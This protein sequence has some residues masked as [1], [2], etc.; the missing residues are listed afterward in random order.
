MVSEAAKERV[1]RRPARFAPLFSFASVRCHSRHRFWPALTLASRINTR[2]AR[3]GNLAE[4]ALIPIIPDETAFPYSIRVESLIT[5]SHGSSSMA[6]VCGGCLAMMSAGVP[7]K[8]VVAGIAMGALMPPE[9]NN[10]EDSIVRARV[11]ER[12]EHI[13]LTS[14]TWMSSK[15]TVTRWECRRFAIGAVFWNRTE[16][17][18][19]LR[20]DQNALL[21]APSV[22]GRLGTRCFHRSYLFASN[23]HRTTGSNAV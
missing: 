2:F 18:R 9:S 3:S 14:E 22:L 5:E 7:I 12:S 8:S 13:I 20:P 23:L 11:C 10:I 21:A 4:R 16:Q 17:A 15:V 19:L 1:L 6:S